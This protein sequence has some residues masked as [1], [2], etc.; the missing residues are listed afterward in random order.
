MSENKEKPTPI[1]VEIE[2]LPGTLATLESIAHS[3][4][5]SIGET[6]DRLAGFYWPDHKQRIL[7]ELADLLDSE[8]YR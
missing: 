8:Y 2:I 3:L 7:T 1:K 4:R 5:L 6:V